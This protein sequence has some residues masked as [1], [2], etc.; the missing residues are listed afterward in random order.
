MALVGDVPPFHS[1]PEV[2]SLS[3]DGSRIW[4][5]QFWAV[6]DPAP[7][8]TDYGEP[9]LTPEVI[10]APA[11]RRGLH[12][13]GVIV[14]SVFVAVMFNISFTLPGF[15][16]PSASLNDVASAL[17]IALGIW[18]MLIYVVPA[19]ILSLGRQGIDV[20]LLRSMFVGMV[21]GLRF[22]IDLLFLFSGSRWIEVMARLAGSGAITVGPVLFGLAA[23]LNLIWYRSFRSLRPQVL[24]LVGRRGRGP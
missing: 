2:G 22:G 8:P 17:I 24:D 9:T 6:R 21:F 1:T 18:A 13:G 23:L 12:I 11:V 14:A 15:L 19:A 5:G 4:T 7:L 16:L 10:E 3:R 20:L